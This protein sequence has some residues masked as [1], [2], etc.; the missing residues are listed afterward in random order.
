MPRHRDVDVLE[1]PLADHVDLAG[2][3]FLRGCA[4]V[5][6]RPGVARRGEP[7][8][9]RDRGREGAGAEQV[10]AAAVSGRAFL[11]GVMV[12]GLRFLRQ[13]GQRVELADDPDHRLAG[14]ERRDERRRNAGDAGRHLESG[15]LQL[16]LQQ[17]AAFQ[18]LE[19]D[20]REAPDL[21]RDARVFL[22]LRVDAAK[23]R[24]A[25]VGRRR[26]PGRSQVPVAPGFLVRRSA[27]RGGRSR[28]KQQQRQC[29]GGFSTHQGDS[30]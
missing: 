6:Q 13:S 17:C 21:F 29:N 20:L 26:L 24:C 22:A 8:L 1:E 4:V 28:T 10:V 19:P 23:H 30:S 18:L 9:H 16:L 11:D 27:R 3:A 7:F 15:G 12:R 2:T 14:P 5:A 25:L